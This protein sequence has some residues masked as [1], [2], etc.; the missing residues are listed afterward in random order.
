[1]LGENM[2]KLR[3]Q[4]GISLFTL[5]VSIGVT[6]RTLQ[7]LEVGRAKNPTLEL[8]NKLADF[9][10]VSLDELTGRCNMKQSKTDF[11]MLPL[12]KGEKAKRS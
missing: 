3:R 5:A 6:D 8:L 9:Y 12:K 10:D 11:V 7:A 1:M 2:R 4:K